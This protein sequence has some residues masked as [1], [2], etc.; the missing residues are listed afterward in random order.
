MYRTLIVEPHEFSIK[1]LLSLPIWCDINDT[2]HKEGFVCSK[3]ASNG[4]EALE[5]IKSEEFD[6]VLTEVNL[7]IFDGL[8]LL[9][10]IHKDNQP[11]LVVFI[12][13]IVSFSYARE[14]FIYGAFDYLPKPVNQEAMESLFKRASAELA[15]YKHNQVSNAIYESSHPYFAPEKVG[16]IINGVTHQKVEVLDEFY[17]MLNKLY[18]DNENV[19][20]PD[21]IANKLYTTVIDGIY[22]RN[23]WLSLYLPQDFHRQIDYLVLNDINDYISYYQRKLT[24]IYNLIGQ[25]NPLFQDETL[26][27]VYLYI[28][29]NPEDDL[30]LT[31]VAGKFY[32]NHTYL[33]NLFSKKSSIRYSQLVTIVKLKR[34][35]YLINYTSIPL[36]DIAEQLGYK[37]FHYFTKLYKKIIGKAPSDYIRDEND[38]FNYSI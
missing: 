27:R 12:S 22:E 19:Q 32:L 38:G 16:N 21:L 34:A 36:V 17:D 8:Q 2:N 28:L 10:Q 37:D 29:R 31:S 26:S 23:D 18:H 24:Y 14:G 35:E 7:P 1:T 20:Q 4:P 25:L 33:S 30:K 15:K 13:D 3:V 9:K 6:L 11:P 5:L